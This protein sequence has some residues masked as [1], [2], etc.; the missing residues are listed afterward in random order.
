[1]PAPPLMTSLLALFCNWSL[2]PVAV[3][4]STKF[5][6]LSLNWRNST[7]LSAMTGAAARLS[8]Q[9]PEASFSRLTLA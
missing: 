4:I 1:M 7:F 2:P 3:S 8:S 5:C 9:V 6:V